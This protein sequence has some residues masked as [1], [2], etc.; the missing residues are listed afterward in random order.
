MPGTFTMMR[1]E[2]TAPCPAEALILSDNQWD[3][4]PEFVSGEL[5]AMDILVDHFRLG[6]KSWPPFILKRLSRLLRPLRD[7]LIRIQVASAP[8]H[9][10]IH[11]ITLGMQRTRKTYWALTQA[12]WSEVICS[13][14]GEFHRRFGASR[15]C[16]QYVMALAWLLCG[17]DRLE[18]C[19]VFY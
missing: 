8:Y 14:E 4:R 2:P 3:T 17:F 15:N 1:S 12:E 16:R 6:G 7:T 18:S 5:E 9:S 11:D 10:S 19:G 13:T